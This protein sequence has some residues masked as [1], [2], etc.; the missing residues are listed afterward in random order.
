LA[1]TAFPSREKKKMREK[2][3]GKKI[4]STD[5]GPDSCHA[6]SKTPRHVWKKKV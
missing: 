3:T 5:G 4:I 1:E 6:P 2:G